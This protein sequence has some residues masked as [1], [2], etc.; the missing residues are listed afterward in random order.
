MKL[1]LTHDD[2]FID[3]FI[4]RT[5]TLGFRDHEFYIYSNNTKNPLQFVKSSNIKRIGLGDLNN[6][7]IDITKYETVYIHYFAD[8]LID[9]VEKFGAK[10]K[11]IWIFWGAD[12][13]DMQCFNK[14]FL[15]PKTQ[16]LLNNILTNKDSTIIR[17][18]SHYKAKY[19]CTKKQ[20]Q[21][22]KASKKF[23]CIA[24]FLPEDIELINKEF[25]HK[26]HH[27]YFTY[28]NLDDFITN[29]ESNERKKDI[30]VGNSANPSN[31]HL[32]AFTYINENLIYAD[33]KIILPLS[34]SGSKEYIESVIKSGVTKYKDKFYPLIKFMNKSQYN[35]TISNVS[36][37]VMPHLRSQA[38][39]NI[40]NLLW[41]GVKLYF[42]KDS[43]LYKFL[44]SK[45]FTLY[46]L[47]NKNSIYNIPLENNII[48]QN[49][50]LLH[51][52]FGE[53]ATIENYM[54]LLNV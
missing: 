44:I 31:N 14:Y 8:E 47:K 28:G 32:D 24:H 6:G 4:K 27:I 43:N 39:G 40:I 10:T 49:K 23:D 9:F 36:I 29:S 33:C 2:K 52:L 1:H 45:G 19:I 50:E 38:F 30:L 21:K 16:K 17:L 48:E 18:L 12:A 42:Y 5:Q 15:A 35:T 34:Y 7:G 41:H 22:I 26:F 13:F 46:A 25:R 37:A 11:F 54:N 3:A 53:K 51:S 20:K